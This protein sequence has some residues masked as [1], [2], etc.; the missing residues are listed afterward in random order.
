MRKVYHSNHLKV[1]SS[2]TLSRFT[3]LCTQ[4]HYQSPELFHLSRLKFCTQYNWN[5][6]QKSVTPHLPL[7]TP[8]YFLSL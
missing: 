1:Y 7:F 2:V 5:S 4:H 8:F 3:L 6:I